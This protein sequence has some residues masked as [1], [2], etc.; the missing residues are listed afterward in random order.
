ML[1]GRLFGLEVPGGSTEA[2]NHDP[3]R[4]LED[5]GEVVA[6]HD[7]SQPPLFQAPD[8]LQHLLGL[9]H[10]ESGRGL[11]KEDDPRLSEEGAR[12]RYLLTLTAGERADLGANARDRHSEAGEQL[13]RA[14]LHLRLVELARDLPGARRDLLLAEEDVG[15]DIE[16]V[17]EGEV[18][19]DGGDP[20]PGRVLWSRD[21]YLAAVEAH[22]PLVSGVDA[23]D[24]LH[25]RRLTGP[26]VPDQADDLT[27]VDGEVDP[28]QSLDRAESLAHLIELEER[29]V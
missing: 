1:L 12:N 6:D 15:D 8:Q 27:G 4:H 19:V 21:L 3:I 10:P 2:Q 28:V 22:R 17:A 29:T 7:H 23:G 16:V 13:T 25:Q 11:V 9:R 20:E 18:L 14:V 5:V 24:R 26:V